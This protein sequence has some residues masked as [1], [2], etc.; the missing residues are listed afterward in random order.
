ML[1]MQQRYVSRVKGVRSI[2]L[3][4]LQVARLHRLQA[5]AVCVVT[6]FSLLTFL[7]YG[8]GAVIS[9]VLV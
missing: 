6:I 2:V 5:V 4:Q 1:S 7:L 9:A 8:R 3:D